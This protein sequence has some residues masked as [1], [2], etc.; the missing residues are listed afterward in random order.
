MVQNDTVRLGQL[1]DSTSIQAHT[2]DNLLVGVGT[3]GVGYIGTIYV[4]RQYPD[5]CG[6]GTGRFVHGDVNPVLASITTPKNELHQPTRQLAAP[7]SES[8]LCGVPTHDGTWPIS[9][10]HPVSSLH[11]LPSTSQLGAPCC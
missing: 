3:R 2:S 4:S 8:Y 1:P 6:L 10:P 9:I 5:Q 7:S 11:V